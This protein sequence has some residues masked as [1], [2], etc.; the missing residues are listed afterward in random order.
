MTEVKILFIILVIAIIIPGCNKTKL[1]SHWSVEEFLIDGKLDEW[2]GYPLNHFE[3]EYVSAGIR[4]DSSNMYLML[5]TRD[6]KIMNQLTLSGVKIWFDNENKKNK[7]FGLHYFG[8]VPADK[9]PKSEF[10]KV[11]KEREEF[12]KLKRDEFK[13][14]IGII[15]NS[16]PVFIV[17][18]QAVEPAAASDFFK[19]VYL[20]EIRMPINSEGSLLYNINSSVGE[21]ITIGVEIGFNKRDRKPPGDLPEMQGGHRGGGGGKRGMGGG[22]GKPGGMNK[23]NMG[24]LNTEIWF[25]VK[26]SE[27]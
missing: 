12:G 18:R 7:K 11:S 22:M 21:E 10:M 24:K 16:E 1:E 25:T 20:V 14:K 6:R 13:G 4:N 27:G 5:A 3:N 2:S 8:E 9:L 19:G 26:L 15:N 17:N 23:Q